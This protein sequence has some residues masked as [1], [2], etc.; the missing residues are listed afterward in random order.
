MFGER[1]EGRRENEVVQ[2]TM[3]LW[4]V[5][6]QVDEILD[7]VMRLEIQQLLMSREYQLSHTVRLSVKMNIKPI[8][9]YV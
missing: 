6:T 4:S 5:V 3:F 9:M 2:S 8:H 7:V 1:G